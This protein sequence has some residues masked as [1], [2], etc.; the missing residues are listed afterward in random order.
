MIYKKIPNKSKKTSQFWSA[1]EWLKKI[2]WLSI[3]N[4]V[5]TIGGIFLL[6]F[7]VS[8]DFLP[9]LD[10]KEITVTLAGIALVGVQFVAAFGFA[11]I[12]PA[13]FQPKELTKLD[14]NSKVLIFVEAVLG[15]FVAGGV[16]LYAASQDSSI[17]L[18]ENA[19]YAI[20]C[21]IGIFFVSFAYINYLLS[22]K[23]SSK[24]L[25]FAK[26][27]LS[28]VKV[29]AWFIWAFII[30]IFSYVIL[31]DSDEIT[32]WQIFILFI[33]PIFFA[34]IS[35]MIATQEDK[36]IWQSLAILAPVCVIIF[37]MFLDSSNNNTSHIF[38]A[39]LNA[40]GLTMTNKNV[41]FVVTENACHAANTVLS[42]AACNW[43]ASKKMGHI[44]NAKLTSRIGSQV[45]LHW[46]F[47]LPKSLPLFTPF[48]ADQNNVKKYVTQDFVCLN[49]YEKATDKT[50]IKDT[51]IWKRLVLNKQDVIAWGY[52]HQDG[53]NKNKSK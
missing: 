14:N 11:L 18:I 42:P 20:Y 16:L 12:V 39:P 30:P 8:I 7:C 15:I 53:K 17:P 2:P 37:G 33:L 5:L 38:R 36:K 47:P 48:P 13:L 3:W 19:L 10:L 29:V 31:N 27:F 45:L 35:I 41:D 22:K 49:V 25:N 9:D 21:F 6:A 26:L 51:R 28:F 40:L 32:A 4:I 43:D 34:I 24:G 46:P 50:G 44:C 52:A 1:M 23:S